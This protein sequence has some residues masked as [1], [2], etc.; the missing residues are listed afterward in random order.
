MKLTEEIKIDAPRDQVYAALN[1]VEILRQA[2]PGCEELEQLSETELT[3]T[4]QAKVGPVKAKFKGSV[5]LSELNPP[6]SYTISGQGKGG[7]AG[8]AKGSA[9]VTLSEDG[10]GTILRYEVDADVGGKLAQVGS[11]LIE[12][13]SKKLAGEF[14]ETFKSLVS[15]GGEAPAVATPEPTEPDGPAVPVAW[16]IAGL[17]LAGAVVLMWGF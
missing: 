16:I 12:G 17:V 15:Q 8:F 3:A 9:K 2:I 10:G 4:V 6:E 13:T 7:A 11:R 1:D 14:F 5:T